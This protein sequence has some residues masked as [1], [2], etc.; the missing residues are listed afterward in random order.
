MTMPQLGP[1]ARE[2]LLTFV[3][4]IVHPDAQLDRHMVADLALHAAN[5]A[6]QAVDRV[7]STLP[8]PERGLALVA[9]MVVLQVHSQRTRAA[10]EQ[11][12]ED[13]QG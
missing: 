13:R 6:M 5:E 9:A 7:T 12:L 2:A 4:S 11:I 3:T 10:F 1:G 8:A